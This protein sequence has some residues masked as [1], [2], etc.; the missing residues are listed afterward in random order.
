MRL[1]AFI[2]RLRDHPLARQLL[3]FAAVGLAATAAHYVVLV[4]LV[5]LIGMGPIPATTCGYAVGITVSYVLNRR[6]T[7]AA[8]GGLRQFAKFA[9]LYLV[10]AVLNGAVMSGLMK[11]G[12]WY[13]WAQIGA[14]ALVMSW[15]FLGARY[16][17]FRDRG[18]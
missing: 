5:E 6:Y 12:I 9:T 17:V 11:V 4:T 2:L 14:T 1:P 18:G 8:R 16:L 3:S 15:N 7:F 10:G 13:L